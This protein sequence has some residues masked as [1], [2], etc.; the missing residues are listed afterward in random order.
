MLMTDRWVIILDIGK[1]FSKASLWD[2]AGHCIAQRTRANP[3]MESAGRLTLDFMGIEGW[4]REAL[5]EFATMGPVSAIVPV[6]HG[7]AM[8][9]VGNDR[10]LEAPLDYEWTGV[11]AQRAAYDRQRDPF[12]ATGSPSLPAGLNLGL[13]LHW[14]EST[15]SAGALTGKIVPWAQYW[16]WVLSGVACAE[17]TSL[18]CHTDLW[19]PYD[20]APSEL[21]RRRGWADRFAPL[22]SAGA[23]LEALQPA[24]A[25]ATGLSRNVEVYCGLHDSNAALLNARSH[26]ELRGRDATILSTGTWFVAMRTP[27]SKSGLVAIEL[28]EA[29][30]CLVN[31]DVAGTPIPSARFM[32]GR[33]IELL[34][35]TDAPL[36]SDAGESA[37]IK[38]VESGDIF[39]PSYT[40][41]V[42]PYPNAPLR[43]ISPI[44]VR[45]GAMVKAHLYAALVADASLDLIGS[46]DTVVVDGRFSRAPIFVRALANLRPKTRVMVSPDEQG[47][48]RGAL[49]L[50]SQG[51]HDLLETISPLPVDMSAYRA[52]WRDAAEHMN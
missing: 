16:A 11:A 30:D 20:H 48:A 8:T 9:L 43:K 35:G 4:L 18:G 1:S 25:D 7:A 31:V 33:E 14:L 42:G 24:W 10:L 49:Q 5:R 45:N 36:H 6:A 13:Q 39:F 52:R 27:V 40:P 37:A 29:R 44:P 28:P 17:V 34:A 32:G 23:V 2:E 22:T 12:V 51:R 50:V 15:G 21:A 41:G 19:R 46:C 38:A 3:R 26:P 47:V